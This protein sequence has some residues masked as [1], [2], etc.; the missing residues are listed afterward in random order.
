MKKSIKATRGILTLLP[1]KQ[2]DIEQLKFILKRTPDNHI[3][4]RPAKGGGMWDYVTIAHTQKCL[5]YTFGWDWDFKVIEHGKEGDSLWVLGELKVRT[6]SGREIIKQQ[7]GRADCKKRRDGTGYLDYGNDLKAATSDAL[8]KCAHEFGFFS[9]VYN[10]NE[11]KEIKISEV[12]ALPRPG[13]IAKDRTGGA[14]EATQEPTAPIKN[15]DPFVEVT[16]QDLIKMRNEI[17]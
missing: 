17:K 9:D 1:S 12:D 8:K 2:M 13:E 5:N 3:Y 6:L 16:E 15:P 14:E 4:Q 7:F 11:Y 10:K